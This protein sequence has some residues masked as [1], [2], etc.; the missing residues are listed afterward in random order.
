MRNCIKGIRV[1]EKSHKP[2]STYARAFSFQHA[3]AC[4][5]IQR[6]MAK[7][8]CLVFSAGSQQSAESHSLIVCFSGN[9]W[10]PNYNQN[11]P[12]VLKTREMQMLKAQMNQFLARSP[13]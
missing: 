5:P 1:L 11:Q 6:K 10:M 4:H 3:G 8:I 9:D 13:E 2:L 7:S 12:V